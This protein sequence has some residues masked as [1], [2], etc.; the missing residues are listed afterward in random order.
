[1]S[2]LTDAKLMKAAR[3]GG[4]NLVVLALLAGASAVGCILLYLKFG[5]GYSILFSLCLLTIA[6]G[7]GLL[8][9]AARRGRWA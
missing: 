7:Y 9:A 8:G 6:L 1:M 4:R 5:N 2:T 3:R